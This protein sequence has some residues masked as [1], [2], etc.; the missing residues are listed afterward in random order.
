MSVEPGVTIN[1]FT[2]KDSPPFFSLASSRKHTRFK[3]V[4]PVQKQRNT[5]RWTLISVGTA[6]KRVKRK[7]LSDPAHGAPLQLHAKI[8]L[9]SM[10]SK[11]FLLV[12]Q[13]FLLRPLL[14]SW[15]PLPSFCQVLISGANPKASSVGKTYTPFS[16]QCDHCLPFFLWLPIMVLDISLE[17]VYQVPELCSIWNSIKTCGSHTSSATI[18]QCSSIYVGLH[19]LNIWH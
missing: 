3:A 16:V 12:W 4:R 1:V 19:L 2:K 14:C 9:G 11:I 8:G 7:C 17:P 6:K 10:L 13:R 5:S 15:W 18:N